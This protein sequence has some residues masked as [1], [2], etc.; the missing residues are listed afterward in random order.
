[1][2]KVIYI[3]FIISI[4]LISGCSNIDNIPNNNT[5]ISN[6]DTCILNNDTCILNNTL[7][8]L[9]KQGPTYVTYNFN[10]SNFKLQTINLTLYQ[11]YLDFYK[12]H[13]V[14]ESLPDE[15]FYEEFYQYDYDDDLYEQILNY[16]RNYSDDEEEQIDYLMNFISS[17]E[18]K[19][20]ED[21]YYPYEFIY[22]GYGVCNEK[23]LLM[24]GLLDR[25]NYSTAALIFPNSNHIAVGI[26]CTTPQYGNYCFMDVTSGYKYLMDTDFNLNDGSKFDTTNN[27]IIDI[28]EGKK[29]NSDDEKELINHL[30]ES[31]DKYD[32]LQKEYSQLDGLLNDIDNIYDACDIEDGEYEQVLVV[33]GEYLMNYTDENIM[34]CDDIYYLYNSKVEEI[35]DIIDDGRELEL[36]L[37]KYPN[38]V[39]ID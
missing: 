4:F 34:S 17:I 14:N 12:E 5:S 1:M 28:S 20:V 22:K 23:T 21:F 32:E 29:Y 16:A 30:Y 15:L 13:P 18:Y 24:I 27:Y 6:N 33:K 7:T 36:E 39:S 38:F 26:E 35:N 9:E 10:D 37:K 25:M 2:K 19:Y 8:L 31:V 3:I 11:S